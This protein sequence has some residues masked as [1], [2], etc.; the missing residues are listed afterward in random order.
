MEMGWLFRRHQVRG[1]IY[2]RTLW[3]LVKINTPGRPHEYT[4]QRSWTKGEEEHVTQPLNRVVKNGLRS[5]MELV[6]KCH[7]VSGSCSMRVCWRRLKPFREIGD[8]LTSKFDGATLVKAVERRHK[9]KLRPVRKNVK[10]PSKKDLV[11]LDDSPDY[12]DRCLGTRGRLCN[13]T[14][15]G[16]TVADFCVAAV[17]IRL[18]FVRLKK[19]ASANLFGVAESIAKCVASKKKSIIATE[20]ILRPLRV[21]STYTS[22]INDRHLNSDATTSMVS[23]LLNRRSFTQVELLK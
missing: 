15:Y 4:Q 8:L 23:S 18:L 13:S 9:V 17:V 19:S 10:R 1:S 12:C 7:G 22:D 16:W 3:I 20:M 11:F 6:C 2:L 14:S 21:G 5:K